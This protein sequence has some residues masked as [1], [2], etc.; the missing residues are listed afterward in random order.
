MLT[1][2]DASMTDCTYCGR[3]GRALILKRSCRIGA[4]ADATK[5]RSKP[6]GNACMSIRQRTEYVLTSTYEAQILPPVPPT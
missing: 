6:R 2:D 5:R 4:D 1:G 3:R